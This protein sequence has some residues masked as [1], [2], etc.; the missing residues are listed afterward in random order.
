MTFGSF[1][2]EVVDTDAPRPMISIH[3]R[4]LRGRK[5]TAMY[6]ALVAQ[7]D[8]EYRYVNSR[9]VTNAQGITRCSSLCFRCQLHYLQL[10]GVWFASLRSDLVRSYTNCPKCPRS[11][12]SNQLRKKRFI[13][14]SPFFIPGKFQAVG[15]WVKTLKSST[16][17]TGNIVPV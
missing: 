10:T 15:V 8:G 11:Y 1:S 4:F 16:N 12:D 17:L 3:V 6:T 2:R 14:S 13:L 5:P 7:Q 9:L